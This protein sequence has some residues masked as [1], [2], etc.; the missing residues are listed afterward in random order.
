[1]PVPEVYEAAYELLQSVKSAKPQLGDYYRALEPALLTNWPSASEIYLLKGD[2]YLDYAWQARGNG[3]SDSVTDVGWQVFAQRLRDANTALTKAWEMNPQDERIARRMITVELGQGKDRDRMEEWFGRAMSLN[4]NYYDACW[5]KL[6]Y[7]EPKWHGSRQDM[8]DFG[9]ECVA[10]EAWGG[11]VPLILTKAHD[12][13]A[14]TLNPDD[15]IEYWKDPEVWSDI[16]SAFEKFFELN[17][18]ASGWHHNYARYAYWAEQWD[19]LNRQLPLLG[20]INYEFFGG[21]DEFDKMVRLTQA[22]ASKSK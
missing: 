10:S 21:K 15:R 11:E 22:H 17:P 20:E 18:D 16:K 3:Y 13:L 5:G 7:L 9:R 19:E 6:Y 4:T 14:K 12:E 8:L 1:M 2:F